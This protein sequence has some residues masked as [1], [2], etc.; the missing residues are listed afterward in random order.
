MSSP[1]D[2]GLLGTLSVLYELSLTIGRSLDFDEACGGFVVPL[3]SRKNLSHAVVWRCGDRGLEPVWALPTVA[4]EPVDI[5]LPNN[6]GLGQPVAVCPGEQGWEPI[7]AAHGVSDGEGAMFALPGIG[8]LTVRRGETGQPFDYAALAQL[9]PLMEQFAISLQ[10][11]D[12]YNRS[13]EQR[14]ERD[15]LFDAVND[16]IVV[17]EPDGRI[18]Q[19]NDRMKTWSAAANTAVFLCELSANGR[20]L[21]A[22]VAEIGLAPEGDKLRVDANDVV[23]PSGQ[24]RT[25]SWSLVSAHI[26]G[27]SRI[28]ASAADVTNWRSRADALRLASEAADEA[29]RAKSRFLSRV[30][31]ELRT[32]LNAVLGFTELA[33]LG[34]IDDETAESLE[35][36]LGAGRHLLTLIDD[37]LDVSRVEAGEL[38]LNIEP[39][40]LTD[41]VEDAFRMVGAFAGERGVELIPPVCDEHPVVMVDPVRARQVLVNLLT[42]AVK[43]NRFEGTVELRC[44]VSGGMASVSVTDTG[45][46]IAEQDLERLFVPFDRLGQE[47]GEVE[48]TGIGLC[49]SR[50]MS[51][52]MG[53]ALSVRS[54]VGTGSTF[55]FEMPLVSDPALVETT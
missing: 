18:V 55:V 14:L 15:L 51:E 54:I 40:P 35:R 22:A 38:S 25:L 26:G 12:A 19:M 46:G 8:V 5:D 16:G 49:L 6:L 44:R 42:N 27:A 10:A 28:V 31:H 47:R 32:P 37:V 34:E 11:C 20:P 3:M 48:G 41:V 30:S 2:V 52:A 43:F 45:P 17:C 50:S 33:T 39:V 36:V 9:Q 4:M 23:D 24:T 13:Q 1:S 7:E 29:N 53:G 21:E